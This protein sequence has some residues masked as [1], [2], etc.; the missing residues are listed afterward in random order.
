MATGEA[1]CKRCGCRLA[2]GDVQQMAVFYRTEETALVAAQYVC[3][4]CGATEWQR[5]DG[6]PF[7]AEAPAVTAT[8]R[9]V[10]VAAPCD[11]PITFDEYL[12]FILA[13]IELSPADMRAL[14]E[15]V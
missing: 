5:Y 3:P 12:D 9:Q 6:E 4:R 10:S 11:H 1:N 8:E 13:L 15:S 7:G 14:H 2:R